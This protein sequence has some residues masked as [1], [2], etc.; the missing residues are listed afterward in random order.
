MFK[1]GDIEIPSRVVLGPMAGITSEAYR[2]FCKPFGVGLSFTEM[3]SDCGIMYEN[4]KTEAYLP[5]LKSDRPIAIQL[6]GSNIETT[7]K[8]IEKI[9]KANICYDFLDLNFGCP[10]PKVTKS[11]AGSA[12]LKDP[13]KLFEYVKAVVKISPKPVL[14]K[15]RLGWDDEH[16]NF[17]KVA[18]LLELAGISAL[19]I[20]A[21]TTKQMYSGKA[22]WNSIKG[23]KEKMSIPLIISGDI[24]TLDDAKQAL[25][26]T[27]ADAVM[28]AR[29]AV[30]NPNLIRQINVFLKEGKEI[31]SSTLDEQINYLRQFS[32]LLIEEKGERKALM[33]LRGLAPK[34]FVGLPKAKQIKKQLTTTIS[35]YKDLEIILKQIN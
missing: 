26:I 12:W 5:T 8:A 4:D 34:F 35:T 18:S 9:R 2:L 22:D 29:G 7:Q 30:G 20:H 19:T 31:P 14:A 10:V 3:V 25:S 28:V 6:F 11:G 13:K 16:I 21:R 15:I 17:Y 33:I 24:F 1:I 32:Q 27:N 23:L